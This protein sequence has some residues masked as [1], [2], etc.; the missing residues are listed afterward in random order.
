MTCKEKLIQDHP[1]Y[2]KWDVDDIIENYCPY[3]YG[4]LSRQ[5]D[6]EPCDEDCEA[7]WN[8]EIID[9]TKNE[10]ENKTM[11]TTT[12]TNT[13]KTKPQLIEELEA[14]KANVTD[15]K[16]QIDN[17]ERYKQYEECADEIKA[18]HTAF[19]NSGFTDEQAFDLIKTAMQSVAGAALRR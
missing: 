18:M 5:T 7:C 13:K 8:Q 6:I 15:L 10:K 4:Y 11:A 12:T 19:M 16:K 17:L 1:Y 9:E 3:H 2:D 14:A